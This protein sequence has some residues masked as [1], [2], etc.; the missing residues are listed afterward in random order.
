LIPKPGDLLAAI[1][2]ITLT[3]C[4]SIEGI[5]RKKGQILQESTR[6]VF[7]SN[8]ICPFGGVFARM[9]IE[10]GNFMMAKDIWLIALRTV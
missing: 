7:G 1:H 3:A 10:H 8:I 5:L 2:F 6:I 4:H 9:R